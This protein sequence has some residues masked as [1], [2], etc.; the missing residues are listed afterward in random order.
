MSEAR[1]PSEYTEQNVLLASREDPEDPSAPLS[2]ALYLELKRAITG[3]KIP[4]GTV[5]RENEVAE[6][7]GASRTPAREALRRLVQEGL[8]VRAGRHYTVRRFTPGEVRDLYEV[9]EGL[10]K[11]AVSLAIE[12]GTSADFGRLQTHLAAQSEAAASGDRALFSLLDTRFHLDIAAIGGNALLLNQMSL[13]HNQVMLVRIVEL[14]RE[15][16]LNRTIDDHRRI[17]DAMMRRDITVAEAEMRYHMRSIVALYHG[18]SEPL[19]DGS[20]PEP[21]PP[22]IPPPTE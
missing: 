8:L 20:I 15:Q 10:E 18:R 22:A 2:Q 11:M 19:P 5:L 7:R 6:Q 1:N 21:D 13:L 12:R 14:S 4:P 9:R 3:F 17:L 16:G